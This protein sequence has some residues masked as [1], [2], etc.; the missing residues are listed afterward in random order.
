M[1]QGPFNPY[2]APGPYM[3]PPGGPVGPSGYDYEFNDV[4]N[5][6][7]TKAAF[8]ARLLGIF[9][10]VS[11][12]ASLLNCNVVSFA[13]DLAVGIT[14]LGA[15]TSLTMVVNTEGNDVQHMMTALG[16]LRTAFKIRVIVVLVA[17]VLVTLAVVGLGLLVFAASKSQ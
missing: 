17:L 4:E 2:T 3:P 6:V 12:A 16:K 5:A 9:M 7:I 10:I 8:W 1:N 13:I 14:F 11:G 15:A